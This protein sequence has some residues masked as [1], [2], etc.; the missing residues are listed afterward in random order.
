VFHAALERADVLVVTGGL[1]PTQDDITRE[2]LSKALGIGLVR[3]P[4]IE[5][6]LRERFASR[7]RAFPESNLQQ[8]ASC[9]RR[10]RRRGWRFALRT[11]SSSTSWPAFRRRC[12]R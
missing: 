11:G 7:G 2:G 5:A 3:E 8:A 1:G 9:R 12:G 4:A 6:F 10:G